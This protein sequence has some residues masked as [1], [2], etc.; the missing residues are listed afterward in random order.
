MFAPLDL[1]GLKNLA[2]T[3]SGTNTQAAAPLVQGE[4][5]IIKATY[6]SADDLRPNQF[7]VKA[8]QPVRL[9]IDVKDDGSGC[10]GSMALPGLSRQVEMLTKGK[11]M[12]FEFT[13]SSAGKFDITC[14][15]GVPRGAI[16][17][18]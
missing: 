10:M 3:P 2:L 18:I 9:E 16:T 13:P 12:V 1:S 14:A 4:A 8:G 17:V 11:P 7:T 6:T 5:Q 15:M